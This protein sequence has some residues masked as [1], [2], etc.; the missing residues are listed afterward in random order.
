MAKFQSKP[1]VIEATQ[2]NR[3]GDHLAVYEGPP[4]GTFWVKSMQGEVAVWPGD[5]IIAEPTLADGYYPCNPK[6][7]EAKYEPL[8]PELPTAFP[9]P[10][11]A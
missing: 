5:W 8:A 2:W 6:V 1:T 3:P 7:F 9:G 11:D 10:G 4:K